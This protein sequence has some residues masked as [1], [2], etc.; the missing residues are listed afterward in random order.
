MAG[1]RATGDGFNTTDGGLILHDELVYGDR[2]L[3]PIVDGTLA[4]T[5]GTLKI[6]AK[7]TRILL[8]MPALVGSAVTGVLTI[9][10]PD[11]VVIYESAA[12]GESDTHII[13]PD[14]AIPMVGTN[15]VKLTLSTDPLGTTA[16]AYFTPYLEGN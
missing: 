9:E 6:S 16:S 10:N 8:E 12:C 3:I 7:C 4:Y 1:T 11:G 14:P 15:T 13:S 2:T 5:V